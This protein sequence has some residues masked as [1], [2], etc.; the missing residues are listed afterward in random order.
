MAEALPPE[1]PRR[2]GVF[3]YKSDQPGNEDYMRGGERVS[4]T[5]F[6]DGRLVQR[7]N[8]HIAVDPDVERAQPP[9]ASSM[10]PQ[11]TIFRPR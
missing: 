9:S 4:M 3:V 5:L 1:R 2:R 11:S 6:P 8:C 7:A 10:D